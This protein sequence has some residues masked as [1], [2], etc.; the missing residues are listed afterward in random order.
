MSAECPAEFPGKRQKKVS[1][2]GFAVCR[3]FKGHYEL[4]KIRW[5]VDVQKVWVGEKIFFRSTIFSKKY[6][7]DQKKS[8]NR[9]GKKKFAKRSGKCGALPVVARRPL[10]SAQRDLIQVLSS[11]QEPA[12]P[13]SPAGR[14]LVNFSIL[15]CLALS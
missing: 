8:K 10:Q 14:S 3:V 5:A 4:P 13:T 9:V 2:V 12:A 11:T 6:F 7:F 1:S 15:L